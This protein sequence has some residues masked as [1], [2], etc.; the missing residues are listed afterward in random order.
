M[1]KRAWY[2]SYQSTFTVDDLAYKVCSHLCSF[3]T[4]TTLVVDIFLFWFAIGNCNTVEWILLNEPKPP[5]AENGSCFVAFIDLSRD[6]APNVQQ[7]NKHDKAKAHH[8]NQRGS[9][10]HNEWDVFFFSLFFRR[11]LTF[12]ILANRRCKSSCLETDWDHCW[13]LLQFGFK[14]FLISTQQTNLA[15]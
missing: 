9:T 7:N 13:S 2:W 8:Q 10:R 15:L 3:L 4:P 11:S 14:F 6:F 12:S 5:M 1:V